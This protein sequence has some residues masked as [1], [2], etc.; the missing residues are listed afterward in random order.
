MPYPNSE[1]GKTRYLAAGQPGPNLAAV[2]PGLCGKN[3]AENKAR[4]R[5]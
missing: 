2:Q 4:L 3:H 1:P 5:Y